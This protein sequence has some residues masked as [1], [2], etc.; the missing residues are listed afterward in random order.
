MQTDKIYIGVDNG[1]S[2]TI[3]IL[4]PGKN[5]FIE[6]PVFK[7]LNFQKTKK[8]N[9]NRLHF[10]KLSK[11]FSMY[12]ADKNCF[13][14]IERPLV[15]GKMFK[16]TMSAV[17]CLEATLILFELFDIPYQYTDSKLWQ[18]DL[19]PGGTIGSVALKE[20]SRDV[21]IRMFPEHKELIRKHGD[22]DGLLLAAYAKKYNL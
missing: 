6:T 15:N 18:K 8:Q 22:A 3:A 7:Q 10:L 9:I 5:I 11:I 12:V 17:R 2:G 1:V 16:A 14:V 21:G 20:A 19:L 13:A 4:T